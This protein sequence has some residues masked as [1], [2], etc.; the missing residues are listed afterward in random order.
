MKMNFSCLV[1][2]R[3]SAWKSIQFSHEQV[4]L[5][6]GTDCKPCKSLPG[7]N[8]NVI[9][10]SLKWFVHKQWDDFNVESTR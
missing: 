1:K 9:R 10:Y 2:S 3:Q 5:A 7:D 8:C 4:Y 6:I